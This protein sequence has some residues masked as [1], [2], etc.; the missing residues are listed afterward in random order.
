LRQE[1]SVPC[2]IFF[3]YN[4]QYRNFGKEIK[5]NHLKPN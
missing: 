5:M 1:T 4:F 3:K 2:A